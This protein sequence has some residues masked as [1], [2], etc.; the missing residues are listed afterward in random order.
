MALHRVAT[1]RNLQPRGSQGATAAV[2]LL[3][4]RV[5]A[6]SVLEDERR[7]LLWRWEVKKLGSLGARKGTATAMRAW[8]KQA[9]AW[10][11][12]HQAA[13][14][15]LSCNMATDKARQRALAAIEKAEA[16]LHPGPCPDPSQLCEAPAPGDGKVSMPALTPAALQKQPDDSSMAQAR[17]S[18]NTSQCATQRSASAEPSTVA[19]P[20]LT[21]SAELIACSPLEQATP[22]LRGSSAGVTAEP[23]N[24]GTHNTGS[25]GGGLGRTSTGTA[26]GADAACARAHAAGQAL[27]AATAASKDWTKKAK[28]LERQRDMHVKAAVKEATRLA[29]E[30][31]AEEKRVAKE[32]AAKEKA[33]AKEAKEAERA[34]KAKQREEKAA[35][36]AKCAPAQVICNVLQRAGK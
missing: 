4:E 31:A 6:A 26:G 27:D 32:Q 18:L 24:V 29:K 9:Q 11:A 20:Q 21:P 1:D 13:V 17:T 34:E 35:E 16:V 10:M 19:A 25:E 23:S 15:A 2:H 12:A 3:A 30:S 22:A 5:K 7:E 14:Q 36:K 28:E 8:F 33:A